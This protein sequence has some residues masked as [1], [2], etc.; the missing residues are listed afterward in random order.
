MENL[1][2][3][4]IK[5]QRTGCQ[6]VLGACMLDASVIPHVASVLEPDAFHNMDE[7]LIFQ[8]ILEIFNRANAS[9]IA[10]PPI[11]A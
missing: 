11:A 8:A 2:D 3:H 7:R 1:S 9:L 6:Y 4:E 5:R 10:S